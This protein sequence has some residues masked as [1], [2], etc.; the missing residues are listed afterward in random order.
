MNVYVQ[1]PPLIFVSRAVIWK[2]E[3]CT[4]SLC[5]LIF[6][7]NVFISRAAAVEP[8]EARSNR[9]TNQAE[10]LNSARKLL[11]L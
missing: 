7:L 8:L 10:K 1:V 3:F 5:M 2:C 6:S 4:L 11:N 9:T